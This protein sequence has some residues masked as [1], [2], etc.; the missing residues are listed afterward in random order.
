[1]TTL[2]QS[3][4]VRQPTWQRD[5]SWWAW[6]CSAVALAF[7]QAVPT[8][9]AL[10]FLGITFIYGLLFP[11]R[12]Y[13]ALLWNF[14]PWM[15]VAFGALS[16]IWSD[17]PMHSARS[18]AQ[19]GLTTLVAI[20]FAQN[21]PAY[22]YITVIM[23]AFLAPVLASLYIPGMFGSKNSLALAIALILLSSCWVMLDRQQTKIARIV[24]L[25]ALLG[26]PMMLFAADSQG[27]LLSGGFALLCS[28]L[29]FLLRSLRSNT[30]IFLFWLAVFGVIILLGS[31]L[32]LL[33]GVF[34][35]ALTSIGKDSTL[36]GRTVLWSQ[37]IDLIADHPFGGLGLQAFWIEGNRGAERLWAFFFIDTRAG[38]HFHNLWL[39][40]GVELGLLGIAIAFLTTLLVVV[41]V[42]Q[43]MLNDPRP[44]SCF[45]AGF[46]ALVVFRTFGEAELY[47]QFY[48]VPMIFLAGYYYA[49]SAQLTHVTSKTS[50]S[51]SH[52]QAESS[53]VP[54]AT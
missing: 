8:T 10:I 52:E 9:P 51:A 42:F 16:V 34:D 38:F 7:V 14:V 35:I 21:V 23:Y 49:V 11:A 44:E 37:A 31:A 15:I 41:N 24:A 29:P 2:V 53:L 20:T 54:R 50:P 39:E 45:F 17:V 13:R 48:L 26:T 32:W 46:V 1:M 19:I 43:W 36:T 40:I 5:I 27:A 25:L 30:R 4:S 33:D 6:L 18:A 22:S 28:F 3:R 47:V 12:P